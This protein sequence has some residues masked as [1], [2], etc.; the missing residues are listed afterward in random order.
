MGDLKDFGKYYKIKYGS[1]RQ[2]EWVKAHYT[3]HKM[4][5]QGVR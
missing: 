2:Y 1:K 5:S 4:L 3:I